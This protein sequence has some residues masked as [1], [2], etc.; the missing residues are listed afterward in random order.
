MNKKSKGKN[1]RQLLI[2]VLSCEPHEN[3]VTLVKI[4]KVLHQG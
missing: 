2:T 1:H 3:T 4:R